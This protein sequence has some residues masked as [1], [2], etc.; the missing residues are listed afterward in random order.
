M[1]EVAATTQNMLQIGTFSTLLSKLQYKRNCSNC[2]CMFT[3]LTH[4][5]G[6]FRC[7]VCYPFVSHRIL[8]RVCHA[9]PVS[10]NGAK[11]A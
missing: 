2:I 9:K 3:V 7:I 6:C 10:G 11:A 8:F 5:Q 4:V 1:P